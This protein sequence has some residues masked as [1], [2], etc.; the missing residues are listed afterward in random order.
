MNIVNHTIFL[1]H[2]DPSPFILLAKSSWS[3]WISQVER[4]QQMW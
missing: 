3:W 4:R 2:S 1:N